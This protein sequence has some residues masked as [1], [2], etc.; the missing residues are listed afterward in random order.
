MLLLNVPDIGEQALMSGDMFDGIA[1]KEASEVEMPMFQ[2]LGL[3]RA[4]QKKEGVT[5]AINW[6]RY[7]I[8]SLCETVF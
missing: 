3:M 2:E 4:M 8:S 5:A 6:Y 7:T 1:T